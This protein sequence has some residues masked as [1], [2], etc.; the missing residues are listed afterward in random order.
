MRNIFKLNVV[1][2]ADCVVKRKLTLLFLYILLSILFLLLFFMYILLN[3][4]LDFE[5][6]FIIIILV[7]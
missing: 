5:K 3:D 2:V 1:V 7:L 6:L 4:D